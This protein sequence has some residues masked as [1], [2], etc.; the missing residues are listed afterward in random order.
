MKEKSCFF[1]GHRIIPLSEFNKVKQSL[2]D[3]IIS[4]IEKRDIKYFYAGGALGFDTL[5]AQAVIDLKKIYDIKL[6]L[7]L[8]CRDQTARWSKRDVEIYN[9]ILSKC[10]RYYYITDV[11]DRGCMLRRNRAMADSCDYCISYLRRNSGG[12]A[13]TVRYATEN[14]VKIT[15]L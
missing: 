8:P 10:D 15:A 3:N 1:T 9:D 7:V 12:T 2:Y 14:N 13:Y 6:V 11:Y 4:L 5:A